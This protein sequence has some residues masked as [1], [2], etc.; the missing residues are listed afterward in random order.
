MI[1]FILLPLLAIVGVAW[2]MGLFEGSPKEEKES[3][4]LVSG[5][6]KIGAVGAVIY[7]VLWVL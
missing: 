6:I 3:T 1:E 7:F 2:F 4:G 5:L